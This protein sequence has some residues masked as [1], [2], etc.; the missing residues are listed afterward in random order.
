M[1]IHMLHKPVK[2]TVSFIACASLCSFFAS[3]TADDSSAVSFAKQA[4]VLAGAAQVCGQPISTFTMRVGE[5]ISAMATSPMDS[6]YATAA[7]SKAQQEAANNMAQNTTTMCPKVVNDFNS[8]PLLQPD[9]EKTVIQPIKASNISTAAASTPTMATKPPPAAANSSA[10]ANPFAPPGSLTPQSFVSA[11]PAPAASNA[12]SKPTDTPPINPG[13]AAGNNTNPAASTNTQSNQATEIAR[14]QLAQQLAQMAQSLVSN[15]NQP[16]FVPPGQV[17][18]NNPTYN[19]VLNQQLYGPG[20]N[21]PVYTGTPLPPIN[22]APPPT[23]Q[24]PAPIPTP[25]APANH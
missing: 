21:N 18:N 13:Y 25:G 20:A 5:V 1:L 23:P 19:S 14:L 3:A 17:S 9:Y 11:T 16:S 10:P 22:P 6:T 2:F 8:L 24:N 15:N 4:G 7:Y 12:A